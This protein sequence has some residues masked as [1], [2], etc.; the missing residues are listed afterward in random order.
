MEI[1][2]FVMV[3]CVILL[4][5]MKIYSKKEECDIDIGQF[6]KKIIDWDIKARIYEKI[7]VWKLKLNQ[8]KV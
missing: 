6:C 5:I 4:I 8:A 1:N 2:T 7:E 3:T